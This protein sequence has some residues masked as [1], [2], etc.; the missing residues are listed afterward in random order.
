MGETSI[1]EL[2]YALAA[3]YIVAMAEASSNLSRYDG[4]R[5]GASL[6]KGSSDWNAAFAK[7]RTE[8]FGQEVKR[9][10]LLG[11]FVLSAGYYEAY[12]V[13]AQKARALLR[14]AFARAFKKYDVLLGPTMPICPPRLNEKVTPLEDY[15]IDVNTV[16][17]NLVGVPSV[18]VPVGY[19]RGLPVGMQLI[20][21][22]FAEKRLFAVA[23]EYE[24]SV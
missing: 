8:C 7:T 23:C 15:L 17:A 24:G 16:P 13:K 1:E 9:R 12:Y 3:Y 2:K 19:S 10:I 20:G 6:D 4:V 22:H 21:P 11:T 18:S 5:Y 14:R